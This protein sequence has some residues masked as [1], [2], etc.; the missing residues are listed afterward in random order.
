MEINIWHK[1]YSDL[2]ILQG[3]RRRPVRPSQRTCWPPPGPSRCSSCTGSSC[4]RTSC[5]P[6]RCWVQA[7]SRFP[8]ICGN[9]LRLMNGRDVKEK[10]QSAFVQT[11]V[12]SATAVGEAWCFWPLRLGC[13]QGAKSHGWVGNYVHCER[14]VGTVRRCKDEENAQKSPGT[15]RCHTS[16]PAPPLPPHC[17]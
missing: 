9:M 17:K 2:G 8:K 13:M 11:Q 6:V 7:F 5:S 1:K 16:Y 10:K 12:H 4:S 15:Q 3:W 14:S